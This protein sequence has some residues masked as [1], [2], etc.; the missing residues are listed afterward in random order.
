M[1]PGIARLRVEFENLNAELANLYGKQNTIPK[2]HV[3]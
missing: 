2:R 1:E 3:Q